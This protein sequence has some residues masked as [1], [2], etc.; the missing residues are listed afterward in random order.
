SLISA[1]RVHPTAEGAEK[2]ADAVAE[3]I[4]SALAGPAVPL[5]PER[6]RRPADWKGAIYPK[7]LHTI[8]A[9]SSEATMERAAKQMEK[10]DA[11]NRSGKYRASGYSI[12]SHKCPDWFV[13]AK[14]GIFVDWGL[15]SIA[16]YA[17]YKKGERLYPDWY[18]QR[19]FVPY[20][21]DDQIF[22]CWEYH[23]KNW[24]EDFKRDHFIDLF[25]G[26]DFDAPKL[27]RL[28]REC[29]AKYVVPFLKHHSGF[30]LW[31]C[32]YTFRDSV[33]QGAHRDF[34]KEIADA[35]RAE[36][37]KFG[38]YNSQA[39]EWEYPLL[40]EDGTLKT[41]LWGGYDTVDYGP[42]MEYVA[43]GKIAVR[44]F[45]R[46]YIV[47]QM[48]EFVEKYD[49][50]L[51]WFDADWTNRAT[52]NGSYDIAA[53]FY[54]L[55][56]GRKEVCVNDRYG[57]LD[58][59]EENALKRRGATCIGCRTVRGDFFTDEWGDTSADIT[60]EAWHPWESCSGISKCYGNHWM[61]E[62][63]P[64]MVMT[65]REFVI[66]FADIVARG[67]NLLLLVN[68]DGQGALPKIQEE[69][70]RSIGEWLGRWGE[71]IYATRILAPFSTE[72][73]DYTASKDGRSRYA[74]VKN[75]A[76]RVTLE[77]EI[78]ENVAVTVVG[79]SGELEWSRAGSGATVAIPAAYARSRLPFCLKIA[80]RR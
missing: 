69:R 44:D 28:F 6:Y 22:G 30:C 9:E 80:E 64:S 62:S 63:D 59:A 70:L 79:E 10:V 8:A 36:N 74:I 23:K 46:D 47:P 51:L 25:R 58:P 76:D 24:G 57:R 37:L 20:D 60:P 40:A 16:S 35:C 65:D 54:N 7:D 26:R 32:S 38:C 61:E 73:V 52:E 55:A 18:E 1:D 49:P 15:W 39:T 17:P 12:D 67:G 42:E 19:G 33:D 41:M 11:V 78:P 68:L 45:V 31:D 56:E 53:Y 66:H 4:L 14:F 77:C 75:A 34:A 5:A 2:L 13:D 71:A 21:P 72:D 3:S 27:V 29:G 48:T 50:D 43:S